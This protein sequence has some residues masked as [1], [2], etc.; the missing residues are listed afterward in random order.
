VKSESF[1]E[2]NTDEG[3]EHS[4]KASDLYSDCTLFEPWSLI[5]LFILAGFHSFF[6]VP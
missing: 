2:S 5:V 1:C 6:L 4:E 3:R